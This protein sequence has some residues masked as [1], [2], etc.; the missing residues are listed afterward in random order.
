MKRLAIIF[1]SLALL[2][3]QHLKI[4]ATLQ[5]QKLKITF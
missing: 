5:I 1:F 4:K 3:V 2:G